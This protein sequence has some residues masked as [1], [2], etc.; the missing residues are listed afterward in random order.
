MVTAEACKQVSA[1]TT[2]E[3]SGYRVKTKLPL[4]SGELITRWLNRSAEK[5]SI[6]EGL[7]RY[8]PIAKVPMRCGTDASAW[9]GFFKET[10]SR[11]VALT[12]RSHLELRIARIGARRNAATA[13]ALAPWI[14][15]SSPAR[16]PNGLAGRTRQIGAQARSQI[17]N[18]SSWLTA[19][20]T[21]LQ[22]VIMA[23][24]WLYQANSFPRRLRH[25]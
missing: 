4:V 20:T 10:S 2:P 16:S 6:T 1:E 18:G 3:G 23:C 15:L 7:A 13:L 17:V 11:M 22:R 14:G 8:Y 25:R 19:V 9:D 24:D 5:G 21:H 12:T